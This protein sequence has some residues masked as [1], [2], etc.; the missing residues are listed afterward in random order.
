[1]S[2]RWIDAQGVVATG[3]YTS[4]HAVHRAWKK[5]ELPPPTQF[6][7]RFLWNEAALDDHARERAGQTQPAI[8]RR[9]RVIVRRA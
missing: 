6:G 4:I 5:G 7:R 3:R 2:T 8:R 9:R 1:M